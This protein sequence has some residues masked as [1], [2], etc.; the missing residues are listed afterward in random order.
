MVPI[1]K[2]TIIHD[3]QPVDQI[4]IINPCNRGSF[5]GLM[6]T[7]V[8]GQ[9]MCRVVF[10]RNQMNSRHQLNIHAALPFTPSHSL[11]IPMPAE[12]FTKDGVQVRRLKSGRCVLEEE[13]EMYTKINEV[14]FSARSECGAP[15]IRLGF[16]CIV[17]VRE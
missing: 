6:P 15:D 9:A 1:D 11:P 3:N 10:K 7:P 13:W 2:G 17:Y 5:L 8:R 4:A 14:R 12:I 16:A